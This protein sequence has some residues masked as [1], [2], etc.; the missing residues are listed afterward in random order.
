MFTARG[1]RLPFTHINKQTN[2]P[3]DN[4]IASV[5]SILLASAI[6]YVKSDRTQATRTCPEDSAR[7]IPAGTISVTSNTGWQ[8]GGWGYASPFNRDNFGDNEYNWGTGNYGYGNFGNSN[9]GDGNFGNGNLGND[10]LGNY[11]VGSENC[12]NYNVGKGNNGQSNIGIGN[13]GTSNLGQGNIGS[14]NSGIVNNGTNNVGALNSGSNNLG[15]GNSGSSNFGENNSGT[16][17]V[18]WN[19]QGSW[20]IGSSNS[21]N[22]N[23]GSSNS[24]GDFNIGFMNFGSNNTGA[25]NYGTGNVGY[26][27]GVENSTIIAYT[28][29]I[30][31]KNVEVNQVASMAAMNQTGW[32]NLNST[33]VGISQSG[34]RNLG[35][36]NIGESNIGYIINGTENTGLNLNGNGIIGENVDNDAGVG[37]EY[38]PVTIT[39]ITE[40]GSLLNSSVYGYIQDNLVEDYSQVFVQSMSA[41]IQTKVS[42]LSTSTCQS[43]VPM[44]MTNVFSISLRCRGSVKITDMYCSGDSFVVFKDGRLWF[45]TPVVS[46]ENDPYCL[47][48]QRDPEEAY[49]DPEFSHGIG[50][51][52]PGSYKISV[53]STATRWGGGAVAIKVDEF[54]DRVGLGAYQRY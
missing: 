8:I 49:Y 51:I 20:N 14:G 26:L 22:G 30:Y 28:T 25:W 54:C 17:N 44:Y 31:W 52:P 4:M 9:Q 34:F 23:V 32:S 21:G 18:G 45:T 16:E 15:L 43:Y 36:E 40:V 11:N 48:S 41:A 1:A 12:G 7:Y 6:D 2:K 53:Y 33:N 37:N 24:D 35:Y 47:R 38:T 10:N 5:L 13:N 29:E 46:V 39:G 42:P 50:W 3:A 27:A 19:N